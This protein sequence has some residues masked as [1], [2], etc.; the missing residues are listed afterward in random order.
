MTNFVAT[1]DVTALPVGKSTTVTVEGKDVALFN[2]AGEIFAID[3]SCAHAG[4]SLGSGRL[5]G[6][7]VTCRAHGLRF[8][9]A[10]GK[11]VGH[12]AVGVERYLARV[13]GG[14]I[15]VSVTSE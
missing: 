15:L 11:V 5:E 7:V 10:T 4:A 14:K 3:D 12:P 8:D 2:V 13:E 1:I 9:V 6:N